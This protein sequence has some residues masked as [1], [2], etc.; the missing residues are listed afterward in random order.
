MTITVLGAG[1]FGTSLALALSRAGRDIH[2]WARDGAMIAEMQATR[3]TGPRLPGYDLPESLLPV[4]EIP[5]RS[6]AYLI[7]VPMQ[8]TRAFLADHADIFRGQ[9]LVATCKGID[10]TTGQTPVELIDAIGA[11]GAMLSGPSFAADIAEALPTALSLAAPGSEEGTRLQHLLATD[12]LRIYRTE[13]RIG[14]SLGGALKNVV[15]LAAGIAMGAGL[16]ESARAALVTRGYAEIIRLAVKMGAEPATLA[17][18]SGFGDLVLTCT[19]E[20]SR[21]YCYGFALGS[22]QNL[23]EGTTEGVATARAVAGIAKAQSVDMPI[24]QAVA[25]VLSGD[26]SVADAMG[27]L[28][29]RPLKEE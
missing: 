2:L 22:G 27:R 9:T 12:T 20:K 1:A 6:D 15:A 7:A 26:L 4:A 23:P 5:A 25:H 10:L 19:S 24:A 8:K 29:S 13:D 17:G 11:Q 18:L 16:G 3:R 14:V 28:L 21:N